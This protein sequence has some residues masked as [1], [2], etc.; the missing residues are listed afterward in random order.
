MTRK[1]ALAVWAAVLAIVMLFSVLFI[2]LEADHD[3]HGDGCAICAQISACV[4][5]LRHLAVSLVVIALA[6]A[7]RL[8]VP[9]DIAGPVAGRSVTLISLKVKLSD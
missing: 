1:R 6:A 9:H 7:L 5:L 4:D 3:C 2:A 8:S